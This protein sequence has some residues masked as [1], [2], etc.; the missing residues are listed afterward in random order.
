MRFSFE[1]AA[2]E[3]GPIPY[4]FEDW[5]V[6]SV[7]ERF[8]F[9]YFEKIGKGYR[10]MCTK[11][12][13]YVEL[14]E[15]PV[16]GKK[17]K[18]P[19][20][21]TQAT[22]RAMRYQNTPVT[23]RDAA[24]YIEPIEDEVYLLRYFLVE[25]RQTASRPRIWY[26]E[27]QRD[28]YHS[29][30]HEYKAFHPGH[31]YVSRGRWIRGAAKAMDYWIGDQRPYT[32]QGNLHR[33][34]REDTHLRYCSLDMIAKKMTPLNPSR[35]LWNYQQYP[36]LEMPVKAGLTNLMSVLC[37]RGGWYGGAYIS[38][39][40]KNFN[41]SG[42]NLKD[43][44]RLENKASVKF[45]IKQNVTNAELAQ[46]QLLEVLGLQLTAKN[47]KRMESYTKH[48]DEKDLIRVCRLMSYESWEKYRT[49]QKCSLH[50]YRD[51]LDACHELNYNLKDSAILKPRNFKDMHDRTTAL[52]RIK[53]NKENDR[54]M[55]EFYPEYHRLYAF[56][57][58]GLTMVVPKT[59]EAI[60]REGK[61]QNHCVGG[62]VDRVVSGNS[63]ILFIRKSDK[64]SENFYT[65]EYDPR[66]N[67]IVQTRGKRN[68]EATEEV[69]VF[70]KKWLAEVT[71]RRFGE[72]Q[73]MRSA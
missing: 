70:L 37:Q 17:G 31:L 26:S 64:R 3:A 61:R 32:Y 50:D 48:Q 29:G 59:S 22:Y 57:A 35:Y 53:A 58:D 27:H 7:F 43:F 55:R 34:F 42:R 40:T 69:K 56:E 73:K 60:I 30:R 71:H 4:A 14:P 51:Y 45:A 44:L 20:C 66:A 2:Q 68:C 9:L 24:V 52:R 67:R 12:R 1:R 15:R 47:L 72:E 65:M 19:H 38:A 8:Q 54:K 13:E 41:L 21:K 36:Q 49:E 18:C 46:L 11:C 28:V 5:L 10:A 23:Q 39:D 6:K 33:I 63:I 25:I 62:Y 16:G